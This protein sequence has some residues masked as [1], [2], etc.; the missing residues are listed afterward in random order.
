MSWLKYEQEKNETEVIKCFHRKKIKNKWNKRRICFVKIEMNRDTYNFID[1]ILIREDSAQFHHRN[2]NCKNKE[3]KNKQ[4]IK[5]S[6]E[7]ISFTANNKLL[8]F[9]F[10]VIQMQRFHQLFP[11]PVIKI[12]HQICCTTMALVIII[13]T[14][15]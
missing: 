12:I 14:I 3:K 6:C 8:F 9:S 15:S 13:I 5:W 11:Q 7:W 10:Y 2:L 4:R 1:S